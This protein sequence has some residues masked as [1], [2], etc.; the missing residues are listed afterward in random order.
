[1]HI[2]LIMTVRKFDI[3]PAYDEWDAARLGNEGLYSKMLRKLSL[4]GNE[5]KTVLGERAY[6]TARSGF[7]P[8][9]GYPCRVN[10]AKR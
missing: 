2:A 7:H 8:S 1:M 3:V 10:L 6:Q 5:H 9:D 4:G